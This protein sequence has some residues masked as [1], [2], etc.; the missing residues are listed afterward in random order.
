M[1]KINTEKLK[2]IRDKERKA[3]ILSRFDEIDK[4]TIRALRATKAGAQTPDDT[5][6]LDALETESVLLRAELATI[7][8]GYDE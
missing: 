8:G 4:A 1:I 7:T 2:A 5:A 6:R 3:E